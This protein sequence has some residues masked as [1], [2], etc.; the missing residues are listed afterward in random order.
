[1]SND[2]MRGFDQR[3]NE[4]RQQTEEDMWKRLDDQRKK[5]DEE[6]EAQTNSL[7][8]GFQ[9]ESAHRLAKVLGISVEE[10][11]ERLGFK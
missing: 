4:I 9:E 10:A 8:T 5:M 7:L 3:I 6:F 1:M 2:M 11:K